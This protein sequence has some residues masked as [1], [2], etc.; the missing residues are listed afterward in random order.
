[1]G[2]KMNISMQ[3]RRLAF[4]GL[5]AAGLLGAVQSPANNPPVPTCT[6][7]WCELAQCLSPAYE[8]FSDIYL[9]P[10]TNFCLGSDVYAWPE[11]YPYSQFCGEARVVIVSSPPGTN[12]PPDYRTNSFCPMCKT[13]WCE[14]TGPNLHLV[15]NQLWIVF[16]PTNCGDY[17]VSFH[18]V[19]TNPPPC[20]YGAT[21]GA[22]GSISI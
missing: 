1:M 13:N 10:G 22:G 11:P 19:W 6:T 9:W 4:A 15:T 3:F 18:E 7:N 5:L 14:V 16:T 17:S 20:G 2:A 12:C 21:C 8:T